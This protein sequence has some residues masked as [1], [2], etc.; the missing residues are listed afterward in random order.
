MAELFDYV[1]TR[2][3]QLELNGFK[4]YGVDD[5]GVHWHTT[6]QQ[7]SG[8]FDGVASTLETSKK[9]WSDGYF[10]NIPTREGRVITVDGIIYGA[11]PE[12]LVNSWNAFKG[13]LSIHDQ[14]LRVKLG[15]I[16]LQTAVRQSAGAPI[17]EWNGL[18]NLKWSISL[19]A[20][21]SYLYASGQPTQGET[22]L[23]AVSGG[24]TYPAEGYGFEG[25]DKLSD[26]YFGEKQ[27]SGLIQLTNSGNAPSPVTI[28]IDGPVINPS[29][30]HAPGDNVMSFNLS[31]GVGSF[32]LIK[33]ETHEILLNGT[34]P[35]RGR[36]PRREW[37]IAV[38][39]TN[40]W[41][42]SAEKYNPEAKMTVSF[43]GAYV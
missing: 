4:L 8:L 41:S 11:C 5:F 23:P 19:T 12:D 36:V 10:A 32:L 37:S 27:V 20:L 31:L 7:I 29:F 33:G 16:E 18:T 13:I 30:E 21:S 24:F 6:F 25:K 42:F 9:V 28:R 26:W 1:D 43:R 40:T 15:S 17:I 38:P 22:R 14:L 35:L 2:D 34:A 3:V 39:G